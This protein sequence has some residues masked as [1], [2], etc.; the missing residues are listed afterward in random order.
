MNKTETD[1]KRTKNQI[2]HPTLS[3]AY[4]GLLSK[5]ETQF[6]FE[7]RGDI[8]SIMEGERCRG[9]LDYI[10][11]GEYEAEREWMKR[12][13][14]MEDIGIRMA[15]Y[16]EHYA[17]YFTQYGLNFKLSKVG[18]CLEKRKRKLGKLLER[19]IE[20]EMDSQQEEKKNE[21]DEEGLEQSSERNEIQHQSRELEIKKWQKRFDKVGYIR[22]SR[23]A[24]IR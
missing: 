9:L 10:E 5:W 23:L 15:N 4:R 18:K 19:K 14:N 21:K 2:G 6:R 13:Y 20:A 1:S 12:F 16:T 8:E 24:A 11:W 3:K 7:G 17:K 22:G